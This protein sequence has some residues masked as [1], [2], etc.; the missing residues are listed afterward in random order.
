MTTNRLDRKERDMHYSVTDTQALCSATLDPWSD[1]YQ[2]TTVEKRVDCPACSAAL[3][4]IN[5]DM[6]V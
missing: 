3:A 5:A 1:D 4:R 2:G 6:E